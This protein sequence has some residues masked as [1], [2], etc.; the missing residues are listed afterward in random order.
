[1]NSMV[2]AGLGLNGLRPPTAVTITPE[3]IKG[4]LTG[5]GPS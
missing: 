4:G 5:A 1:M 2:V 3:P